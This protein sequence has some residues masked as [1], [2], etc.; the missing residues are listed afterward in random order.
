LYFWGDVW[1]LAAWCE[2]RRDFRNFRL[3]RIDDAR[4]APERFL[5]VLSRN[6]VAARTS[7][8]ARLRKCASSD[9][10]CT[11]ARLS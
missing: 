6:V 4:V 10:P 1:T 8:I 11:T 2:L 3:D 7:A 9:A 5:T